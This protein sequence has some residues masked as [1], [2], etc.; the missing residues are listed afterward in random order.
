MKHRIP[1]SVIAQARQFA[2]NVYKNRQNNKD[3][4][5][6]G[7]ELAADK[8][9]FEVEFSHAYAFNLPF[10]SLFEDKQVDDCDFLMRIEGKEMKIDVKNSPYFLINK[11]QFEKKNIDAYIFESLEFLDYSQDLIYLKVHGWIK[12][13]DVIKNSELIKFPNGSEAYKIKK[14]NKSGGLCT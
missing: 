8:K 10:P 9:G 6:T 1:F 14:L 12:K 7:Q 2:E 4:F 13:Q 5:L 11:K 3:K